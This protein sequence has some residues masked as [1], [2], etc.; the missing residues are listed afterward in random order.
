M[1]L[2]LS[3]V[4][5][6]AIGEEADP[7]GRGDIEGAIGMAMRANHAHADRTV[8]GSFPF[9]DGKINCIYK[10]TQRKRGSQH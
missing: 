10:S 4:S 3:F 6:G 1:A 5:V 9:K 2:M 7:Y 8:I